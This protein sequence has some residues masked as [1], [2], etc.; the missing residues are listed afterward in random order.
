MANDCH[1][2]VA[3]GINRYPE[4]RNLTFAKGDAEA[5]VEWL[6]RSDGGDVPE[7]NAKLIVVEDNEVPNGTR[8][9]DAKPTHARVLDEIK[10]MIRRVEAHIE[11]HPEDWERT[12]FY[13]FVS[14]H[15]IAPEPND[16]ALL[17]ANAGPDDLGFNIPAGELIRFLAESKTFRE[18][19]VFAD[20]CR[21]RLQNTPPPWIPWSRRTGDRGAV[22]EFFGCATEY[23]DLAYEPS[24]INALDPDDLRGY[25][26]KAL[27]EGLAGAAAQV[28]DRQ[29]NS[30]NLSRYLKMRVE[31]LTKGRFRQSANTR[32]DPSVPIVFRELNGTPLPR[33]DIR[34]HFASGFRGNAVLYDGNNEKIETAAI[35]RNAW[36]VLLPK[37]IYRIEDAAGEEVF[38]G[39]GCFS[40][41]GESKTVDV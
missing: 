8:R 7:A 17:T 40:V 38:D 35:T 14:G 10:A 27:L 13:L 11:D 29:I 36:T 26:T 22:Q 41:V 9:E 31:E 23:G 3:V 18:V 30:L 33:Y 5:F 21:E 32:T 25:F 34:I 12:R 39:D 6:R 19:V 15:G 1:Y 2:A 24:N 28:G 16:A 37:G 20:C 4:F